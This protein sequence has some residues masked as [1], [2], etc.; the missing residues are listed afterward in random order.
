MPRI[1]EQVLDSVFYLYPSK[2]AALKRQ[3]SGG[4]GFIVG[5]PAD[6]GRMGE[7]YS[8]AVSNRHVVEGTKVVNGK[9]RIAPSTWLR[10][11]AHAAG[12]LEPFQIDKWE[13]HPSADLTIGFMGVR[14]YAAMKC[15]AIQ[16]DRLLSK[17][18]VKSFDF[19]LGDDVGMVGRFIFYEGDDEDNIPTLRTGVVSAMPNEK[20]PITVEG[21]DWRIQRIPSVI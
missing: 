5:V 6:N 17:D 1:D 3:M 15:R 10:L 14:N 18:L 8:Y 2:I 19:G 11:N 7:F 16:I 20:K 13:P 9:R 12:L 21:F 4:T